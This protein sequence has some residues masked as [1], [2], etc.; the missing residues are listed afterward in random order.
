MTTPE[1]NLQHQ[2]NTYKITN[3]IFYRTEW[4]KKICIEIEKT[5]NSQNSRRTELGVSGSL[6]SDYTV[7]LQ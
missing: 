3:V 5:P 6:T 7:N 2:C 4:K 1:G